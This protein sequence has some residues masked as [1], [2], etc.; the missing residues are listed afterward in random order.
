MQTKLN[1]QKRDRENESLKKASS[2]R[3]TSETVPTPDIP[4]A[5]PSRSTTTI[6][7]ASVQEKKGEGSAQK[8]KK[9]GE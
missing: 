1:E 7:K 4:E 9:K 6:A 3:K 2:P 5:C 8:E